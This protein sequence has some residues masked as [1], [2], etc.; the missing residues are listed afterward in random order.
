[1]IQYNCPV[2]NKAGLPDYI[3]SPT[4]C[5]QCNSDLKSFLLLNSISKQ[6]SSN[7]NLYF[8]IGSLIMAIILVFFYFNSIS[9]NKRSSTEN[10]TIVLQ[11]QD[12]IR[13]LK[14][15]IQS[16]QIEKSKHLI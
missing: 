13:K 2:C 9:D 5:P 8:I 4:I 16:N 12:S 11:L 3:A 15:N 10:S 7:L 14:A 6:K 1:M